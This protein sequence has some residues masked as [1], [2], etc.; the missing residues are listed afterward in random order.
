MRAFQKVTLAAAALFWLSACEAPK[1]PT[2]EATPDPAIAKVET[3]LAPSTQVP[4][5]PVEA[6]SLADRMAFHKVP[7]VSI[8]VIKDGKIA[9]AKGYGV[10]E[11][12]KDTPV[13][14]DTIF[15]AGSISKP[16]AV[17]AALR[18]VEQG[19]LSLDAPIN[20]FLKS[21]KLPDN[22]FTKQKPVT[23]R[24][25]MSHG[26]GLTV[27]GF[28]GYAAGAPIPTVPQILDGAP[29]ANTPAVRV[30]KL[31][32]E[33]FRYSGGGTTILQLAMTDVSAKDFPTLTHDLIL[34]PVGMTRSSFV[35]PLPETNRANAATAHLT[36]GAPLP[37]HS[38]TYPEMAAA[39]LWTTPSDLARLA[40]SVVAAARG[41]TGAILGPDMTKQMLTTQIG[42]YGLGFDLEQ[43]G[44]GQVFSHGGSDEGFEAFLFSYTDGRGGGAIMT[45]GQNG[46]DLA[47]EICVSLAAAYGWKECAPEVRTVLTLTPERAAQFAGD[48]IARI[49]FIAL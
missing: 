40:L 10:L 31:P 48:Y 45:N 34:G 39:G 7:G 1:P 5:E 16:T 44:D 14:P 33:S 27:H 13:N 11:A 8:A 35:N 32:G 15:L 6:W 43:P 28:P 17:M 4:G 21:W 12:G 37:G 46:G 18:M 25:I 30:D 19:Q 42:T 22:D 49:L 20:D 23:P 3:G 2:A 47:S 38:H 9:W 24:M 29:P 26:A 36:D 41:D